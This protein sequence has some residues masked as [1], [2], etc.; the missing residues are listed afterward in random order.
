MVLHTLI[1]NATRYLATMSRIFCLRI[2]PYSPVWELHHS[3]HVHFI[4][5]PV[6][7]SSGPLSCSYGNY[8]TQFC[9]PLHCSQNLDITNAVG[10]QCENT[11]SGGECTV[12]CRDGFSVSGSSVCERGSWTSVPICNPNPCTTSFFTS[13][14]A[15]TCDNVESD[16]RCAFTC[17]DGYHATGSAICL[18]SVWDDS[19][20][21]EPD[22]C[23]GDPNIEYILTGT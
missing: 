16:G 15:T 23:T 3:I 2:L 20:T 6:F 10:V 22:D 13:N 18:E 1:F 11:P 17:V 14:I 12:Q 21:C 8:D 5:N 4:A 7:M 9:L 19:E